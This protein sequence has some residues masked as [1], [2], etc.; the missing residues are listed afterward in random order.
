[1]FPDSNIPHETGL[2]VSYGHA[3]HQKLL[4]FQYPVIIMSGRNRKEIPIS[5]IDD[6]SLCQDCESGW[7]MKTV[8]KKMQKRY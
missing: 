7:G 3:Y 8:P 2:I 6:C 1:V 4:F 5:G